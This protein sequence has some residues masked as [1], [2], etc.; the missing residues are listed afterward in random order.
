MKIDNFKTNIGD[1]GVKCF[2]FTEKQ[3]K[4]RKTGLKQS[5]RQNSQNVCNRK[6]EVYCINVS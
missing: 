2:A 5:V 6:R 1:N 4:T 3:T